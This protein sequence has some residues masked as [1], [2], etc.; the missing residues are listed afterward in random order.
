MSKVVIQVMSDWN[1]WLYCA[2]ENFQMARML[3]WENDVVSLK[4]V[5]TKFG[6]IN[7]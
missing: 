1:D 6:V 7:D 4:D 2:E 5:M 3:R